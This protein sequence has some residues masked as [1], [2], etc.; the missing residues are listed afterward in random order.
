MEFATE[1]LT[2]E[3]ARTARQF[4]TQHTLQPDQPKATG[5]SVPH[6]QWAHLRSD[7]ELHQFI[8]GQSSDAERAHCVLDNF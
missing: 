5:P 1:E 3:V 4:A 2:Q 7:W 8:H 6:P